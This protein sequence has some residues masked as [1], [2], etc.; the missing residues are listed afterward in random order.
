LAGG[1]ALV[2]GA[3]FLYTSTRG[4]GTPTQSLHPPSFVDETAAAGLSHVYDGDFTFF[5]GG[6]VA[7]FDCDDDLLPD[8][9]FAGGTNPAALYR[10]TSSP[11]GR[12]RFERMAG[13]VTDMTDVT[14]AYP[15]DV[16][17]DGI[18]DLAVLRLGPNVM[19]RGLGGCRYEDATVRWGVEPGDDWTAAFSATWEDDAALPTMAFG[20][21]IRLDE[22]GR[23]FGGCSDHL[24]LRP[25][26]NGAYVPTGLSPGWCTLSVLFSDWDRTGS[27]DLRA[28]N[29]RHYYRDGEEQL[30]QIE[31]GA[32]PRLYRRD[33]GWQKMQIWGMGIA[34]YD[35]TG[36]G[37]PEVFLTSQADNKL[38][39]L[40]DGATGPA[41]TDLA[42]RRGATAHR[43]FTGGDVLPSTA[44][45]PEFQD[46]N[47][48]GFIDLFI[49]KGNVEATPGYAEL[50]PNNLLLGQS[51]GT[52]VE[53]AE[54]AG[55]VDFARSRGAA[56]LDL[57][58]D[59]MLDLVYVNRR[60]NVRLWHNVGFGTA[61]D[62]VP[63]GN[64][65]GLR[66]EQ[67]GPNRNAIGAW[68]EVRIGDLISYREITIGG[69]HA[70]G[71]LGWVHVGLGP[72]SE[73]AIRVQWPDGSVG[74]WQ[75]V[76]ANRFAVIRKSGSE[77]VEWSPTG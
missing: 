3:T 8:L 49:T 10:N 60:E 44:W 17:G 32:A 23:Q 77:P 52:F 50:D 13:S 75:D 33:E 61:G 18:T 42:I 19:L 31:A 7:A 26:G 62:P 9:Y 38:Q 63:M 55:I 24:L 15:L 27:P 68:L 5:V 65:I 2:L 71:Q 54:A 59:G 36:D 20:N 1:L 16:D 56:V 14:G 46:V 4:S 25:A 11:G 35:V 40:Q 72:A 69:G 76:A 51:D 57:N 6:G 37:L 47:N 12:I 41:Y 39:T 74:P 21:Y 66:L 30:W 29:D 58:L 43:P 53:S 67:D 70:G 34:T 22:D 45:H 28:T 64:W 73:A 48:D